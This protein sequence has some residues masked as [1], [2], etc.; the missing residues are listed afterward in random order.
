M[1]D[2]TL[3]IWYCFFG[4][5]RNI[6]A[7]KVSVLQL[8][9]ILRKVSICGGWFLFGVS[10]NL[11]LEDW[12]M[13]NNMMNK[14]WGGLAITNIRLLQ[15]QNSKS[16][17]KTKTLNAGTSELIP[18]TKFMSIHMFAYDQH[19]GPGSIRARENYCSFHNA[20]LCN[21]RFDSASTVIRW[22][23]NDVI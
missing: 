11:H 16:V 19:K 12:S 9:K 8:L 2:V 14:I 20:W 6:P 3:E 17:A 1:A 5:C 4:R 15:N 10:Y 13:D 23:S 22:Y 7:F 18:K 21:L